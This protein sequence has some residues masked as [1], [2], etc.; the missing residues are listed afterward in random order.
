MTEVLQW[1]FERRPS[2]KEESDLETR[3]FSSIYTEYHLAI[4]RYILARIGHIED[5]Q[6]L[7]A[8]VFVKAYENFASYRHESTVIYWLIGITR[9]QIADYYRGNRPTVSLTSN[10]DIPSFSASLED[11]LVQ[12][13]RLK[14]VSETLNTLSEDRRDAVTMRLF[15]GLSN[16]EIAEIMGKSADAVAMLVYRGIQD[17]KIRLNGETL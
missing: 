16:Q 4:Y 3:D 5:S 14:R 11:S 9:H 13:N 12:K 7:T 1:H 2:D 17:L 10:S 15:S 6:D 8:Q